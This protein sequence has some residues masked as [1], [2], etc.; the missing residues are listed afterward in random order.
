MDHLPTPDKPYRPIVVPLWASDYDRELYEYIDAHGF[1]VVELR[2]RTSLEYRLHNIDHNTI[3]EL[4]RIYLQTSNTTEDVPKDTLA[5]LELV[6]DFES[7]SSTNEDVLPEQPPMGIKYAARFGLAVHAAETTVGETMT[8]L[9]QLALQLYE[10]GD[11]H[12]EYGVTYVCRRLAHLSISA[13]T[14]QNGEDAGLMI[15]NRY[16]AISKADRKDPFFE[17]VEADVNDHLYDVGKRLQTWLYFGTL[18]RV[19]RIPNI[20]IRADDF[21]VHEK[22]SAM[23][24]RENCQT[25]SVSG[26]VQKSRL[27]KVSVSVTEN[28]S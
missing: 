18:R 23:S 5:C 1:D 7:M 3:A 8:C 9:R 24:Q 14:E 15:S 16:T 17:F 20:T 4:T 13:F 28:R 22:I 10:E 26:N 6:L 12:G 2:N 11:L 19:F 25:I 21:T 27:R